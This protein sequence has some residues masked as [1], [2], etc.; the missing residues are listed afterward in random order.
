MLT[1]FVAGSSAYFKRNPD[2]WQ[3]D[4]VFP[5]NKL[6]YLDSMIM[7]Y[8]QDVATRIAGLRTGK[9]DLVT[10]Y[11]WQQ[12]ESITKTNPRITMQKTQG[13]STQY[14]MLATQRDPILKDIRVRRAL[15]LAIDRQA[16]IQGFY[17]GNADLVS[18][19]VQ[20]DAKGIFTPFEQMPADVKEL[21]EY[22]PDKAKQLLKE[23]GYP[24]GFTLKMLVNSSL[25]DQLD[26]VASYWSKVGVK[27]DPMVKEGGAFSSQ[28]NSL[29]WPSCIH[30]YGNSNPH[31]FYTRFYKTGH[32]LNRTDIKDSHIDEVRTKINST[33]NI[34]ERN[35][36]VRE[37]N[38]YCLG[39]VSVVNLPMP[40]L[41]TGWQPWLKNYHGEQGQMAVGRAWYQYLWVDQEMKK[42]IVG[43]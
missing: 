38:L 33:T 24:D 15:N 19:A 10:E 4:P 1:D 42:T 12:A 41:Y 36:L 16:M 6:P 3:V 2:Y 28:L 8:I 31:N 11:P 29:D 20:P 22:K 34:A 21:W 26:I 30:V 37:L 9:I 17:G 18:W 39:L 13:S 35:Q 27:V 23:A 32:M 25:K 5:Q 7:L 14:I 43:K 40:N